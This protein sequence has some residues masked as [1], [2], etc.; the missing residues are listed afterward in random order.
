MKINLKWKF[1]L[2]NSN[3]ASENENCFSCSSHIECCLLLLNFLLLLLLVEIVNDFI[4]KIV[5]YLYWM[6]KDPL[7]TCLCNAKMWRIWKEI[8]NISPSSIIR[9][10]ERFLFHP[11]SMI[12]RFKN[13]LSSSISYLCLAVFLW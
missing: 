8:I 5:H 9:Q 11:S 3:G 1:T 7:V 6:R 2:W 13:L 12:N 4:S 10:R